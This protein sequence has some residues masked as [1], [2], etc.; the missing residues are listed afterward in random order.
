MKPPRANAVNRVNA[1]LTAFGEGAAAGGTPMHTTHD[2]ET[3]RLDVLAELDRREGRSGVEEK[4][5]RGS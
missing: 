2:R 3:Q 4:A 5:A 1:A